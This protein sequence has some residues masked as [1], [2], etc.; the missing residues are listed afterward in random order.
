MKIH[1]P[2]SFCAVVGLWRKH[3]NSPQRRRDAETRRKKGMVKGG[4]RLKGRK[5]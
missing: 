5:K 3:K 2:G 1:I 4:E